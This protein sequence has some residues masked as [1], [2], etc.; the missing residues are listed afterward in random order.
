MRF[1]PRAAITFTFIAFGVLVGAQVGAI[2]IL[3]E[4][5]GVNSFTFGILAGLCTAANI[6]ALAAGGI[7]SRRFDHRSVILFIL[8]VSCVAVQA[9]L[10]S[11]SV[12]VFGLTFVAFNYC[13][14]T[15]D[16]FMNAEASI[17]EHDLKKPVFAAFHAAVLYAIGLAGLVG[18]YI[19]V[20]YG[21]IWA[22][23]PALPFVILALVSVNQ[24][25]PHRAHVMEARR[26]ARPL[27]RRILFL[28]GIMIGL[29]VAAELTC[30]Q[31]SG[32]LLADMQPQLAQ[33]SGLGVAFYGLCN[34]TVRQVGDRLRARFSDMTLVGASLAVGIA[35]FA[36][37]ATGPGFL[38]SVLAFAVA[39]CGLGLIFPCLFSIA[40][41]LAPDNRAAAL[42][43]ASAV[44]GP[45]RILLPMLLGLLA[46]TYGMHAIY[47]AAGVACAVALAVSVVTGREMSRMQTQAT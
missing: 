46:Q 5:S 35:G 17:V 24:A 29:D 37:L 31:W 10:L 39:G 6:V 20:T 26:S 7:M 43:F 15:L 45:P 13:L 3:R 41:G 33:Y 22:A 11:H 2:P 28:I 23:L 1:S 27:P 19:A 34:G 44:S 47:I 8:P 21:A 36:V 14:G 42:G 9:S 12:I 18:G 25:I 32:Q 38:V 40:A 16:L 4:Q 30:V